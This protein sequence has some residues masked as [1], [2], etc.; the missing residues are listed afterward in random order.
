MRLSIRLPELND[1]Q[2]EAL[3]RRAR[4][5]LGRHAAEVDRVELTIVI[6]SAHSLEQTE[7]RLVVKLRDG[8]EIRVNDDGNQPHRALLRAAR[9]IE[10]RGELARLRRAAAE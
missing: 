6:E 5:V 7:C 1:A 10:I 9:R 2:H 8:D 4:L 3:A